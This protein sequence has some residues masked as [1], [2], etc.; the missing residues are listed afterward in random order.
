ME[1]NYLEYIQKLLGESPVMIPELTNLEPSF[2]QDP[3]IRALIFDIYGTI[4]ISASGDIEESDISTRNLEQSLIAT[5]INILP[6]GREKQEMLFQMLEEFRDE[7]KWVH[8]TEKSPDKPY[9]EIDILSIWE[10]IL[11]N[12]LKND[13]IKFTAPLCIKCFTFFF[14]TLS[15]N[16]YPMPRMKQVI[17]KLAEKG[18]PLGIISNAQFYTPVILN[19]F[20]NGIIAEDENVKPFD[21]EITVYSYKHRRAKPDPYLFEIATENCRKKFSIAPEQILFIGNDMF[22]DIY[23]AHSAGYKT[24]LFA[25]DNRSLRLRPDKTE[26]DHISPDYII[27]DLDQLLKIIV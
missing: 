16:I 13:N 12:Q 18:M 11:D 19:Y 22:R 26:L 21:P 15:N 27:T 23:P 24:A 25:G 9:P 6:T 4:M 2:R 1:G 5:G 3:G 10:T 7:I 8:E 14:E 17:N 20:L